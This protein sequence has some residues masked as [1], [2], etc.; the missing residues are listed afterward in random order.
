MALNVHAAAVAFWLFTVV[1]A[2]KY[3]VRAGMRKMRTA[4]VEEA[5][6]SVRKAVADL[7]VTQVKP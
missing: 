6:A 2:F 4:V 1:A 3:G 5:L 7:V